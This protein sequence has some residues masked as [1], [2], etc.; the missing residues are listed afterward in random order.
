MD[1]ARKRKAPSALGEARGAAE[2]LGRAI[3]RGTVAREAA[4]RG[5][6]GGQR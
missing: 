2:A 1:G 3:D 6:K 5:H 4:G